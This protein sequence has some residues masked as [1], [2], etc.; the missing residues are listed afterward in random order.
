MTVPYSDPETPSRA[1]VLA[2]PQTGLPNRL[3]ASVF[4]ESGWALAV[5]GN[6]LAVVLLELDRRSENGS[7]LGVEA[8][9]HA[10]QTLGHI[11]A[12]RTRRMDL[13]ARYSGARFITILPGCPLEQAKR[14]ARDIRDCFDGSEFPWGRTKLLIGVAALEDG[15]GSPD[16]LL[17]VADR[18]LYLASEKGRALPLQNERARP[19]VPVTEPPPTQ[20]ESLRVLVADD[21]EATL[22]A[23]RRLLEHGYCND[24]SKPN[25]FELCNLLNKFFLSNFK[26]NYPTVLQFT[27]YKQNYDTK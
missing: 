1:D 16:V 18:A 17:A 24:S 2:D 14:Y 25:S 15:M 5:R 6:G 11:L 10:I 12:D 19:P 7:V 21:D 8:A 27:Q 4:L 9:E 23:T 22:R 20:L 13:C 26:G 3:H